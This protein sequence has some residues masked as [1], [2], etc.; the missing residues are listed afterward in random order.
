MKRLFGLLVAGLSIVAGVAVGCTFG[1]S[2]TVRTWHPDCRALADQHFMACFQGEPSK[3]E[4]P[5]GKTITVGDMQQANAEAMARSIK[6]CAA[7]AASL[8]SICDA[9]AGR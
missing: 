8:F 6:E 3:P 5:S 2:T 4:Y 7:N 1:S 9:A